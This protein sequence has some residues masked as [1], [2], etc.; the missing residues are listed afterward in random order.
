MAEQLVHVPFE[1][2]TVQLPLSLEAK[3]SQKER[4][5]LATETRRDYT[6]LRKKKVGYLSTSQ[7]STM[8][9]VPPSAFLP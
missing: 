3:A 5:V 4:L 1:N 8:I 9:E 6:M 2:L 7:P